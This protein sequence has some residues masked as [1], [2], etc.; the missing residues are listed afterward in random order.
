M[1]VQEFLHKSA[2]IMVLAT[3]ACLAGCEQ[4]QRITAPPRNDHPVEKITFVIDIKS[5]QAGETYKVDGASVHYTTPTP[6]CGFMDYTRALGGIYRRPEARINF[7]SSGNEV[8]I[9]RDYFKPRVICPFV[10]DQIIVG[11]SVQNGSQVFININEFINHSNQKNYIRSRCVEYGSS[12]QDYQCYNDDDSW[13]D[14]VSK[15]RHFT[16]DIR[17]LH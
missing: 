17:R 15:E 4:G 13:F 2:L 11:I 12:H 3:L 16:V 7:A 9:Y 1:K 14:R 8:T 5:A 10:I 6:G